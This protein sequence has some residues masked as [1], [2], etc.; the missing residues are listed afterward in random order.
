[1]YNLGDKIITKKNHPCGGNEWRIVRSGAD[2][3]IKC[4]KCGRVVML[5][6]DELS[7][8]VRTVLMEGV[9]DE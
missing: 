7:R 3:K 2:Y 6:Y 5:T 4:E 8:R 9:G 1:M